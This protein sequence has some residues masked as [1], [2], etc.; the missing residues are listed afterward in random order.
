M[1][2]TEES[3]KFNFGSSSEGG[4]GDGADTLDFCAFDRRH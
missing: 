4:G 1:E 2:D 3:R